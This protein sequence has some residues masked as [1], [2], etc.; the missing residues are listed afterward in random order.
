MNQ[1]KHFGLVGGLGVGATV[2]YY[3]GIAAACAER[4]IVPRLTM[5]NAHAPTAL[6]LVQ[7]G[8]IEGLAAYLAGF[9]GEL[10]AAGASFLPFLPS[11]RTS[12]WPTCSARCRCPSSMFSKSRRNACATGGCRA[13]PCSARSS[14][15]IASCSGH[16]M[17]STSFVPGDDEV[18]E[19]HR[20]YLGLATRDRFQLTTKQGC[21]TWRILSAD[22]IASKRSCWLAPTSTSSSM[23][24]MRGFPAVDCAAA[25]IDAIVAQMSG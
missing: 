7:A 10:A 25:H 17:P 19:I 18:D 3:Q 16:S 4:N 24:R 1:S 21:E 8:R 5:A 20:I 23:K 14:R 11:P 13:L 12:A 9:V 15:S 22:V 6:A 2:L